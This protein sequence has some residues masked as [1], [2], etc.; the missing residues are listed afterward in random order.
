MIALRHLSVVYLAAAS[1]F[2]VAIALSQHPTWNAAAHTG[3]RFVGEQG[4]TAAVAINDYVLQPGWAVTKTG[5]VALFKV[6]ADKFNM[7]PQNVAARAPAK[8]VAVAQAKRPA[9]KPVTLNRPAIVA[10]YQA[11]KLAPVPPPEAPKLRPPIIE[12]EPAVQPQPKAN[13]VV[14]SAPHYSLAPQVTQPLAPKAPAQLTPP[15][16]DDHPPSAAELA[17]VAQH[18]RSSL[19]KEMLANFELFLYVSKADRGI[20]AQRMYVFQKQD[21]GDLVL[22]HNWPVSTGRELAEVAPNGAKAPSYTPAGYYELDPK[23]MYVHHFSG[24]W[25]QPMPYA[26]FF[27]WEDH[28]YQTGLAIHGASGAEDIGLLGTRASA[29]CVRIAP[30]NARVLFSLIRNNYKGLMPKFAYDKRTATMSN[31]GVLVHARDGSLEMAQGYKVLVFIENY[32]GEN[33]VAALF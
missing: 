11:R 18:F 5:S 28:G 19:T 8:P 9:P 2:A 10:S 14:A 12:S 29:G 23:R 1:S 7:L 24:Q 17:R 31:Q 13:T 21:S 25:K 20:A 15:P 32:G 33:V 3:A 16:I 27:N 30:E 6:A 22:L 4:A 26:M